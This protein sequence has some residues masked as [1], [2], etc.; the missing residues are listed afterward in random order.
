MKRRHGSTRPLLAVE[1]LEDR[2]CPSGQVLGAALTTPDAVTQAHV[3]AAYG[4]LP[5]AFEA[6]Q[7]Q[8]DSQVNFLS[9]GNGYTLFLK[10]SEAVLDLHAAASDQ[11]LTM[12]LVGANAR[13]QA[14]GL[15]QQAGASNYLIGN[16]PSQWH[17]HIANFD[18]VEY[19][20]VYAGINE[21]YY[22]NQRQ[23][24]YDF[25][26]APGANPS[27]IKL[28]FQG[29]NDVSLDSQGNLVLHTADGDVVEHA[30]VVYQQSNGVR[31]AVTGQ[32][33]LQENGQIGFEVGTY[34]P[35]QP[36]VID[37]V[38]ALSYST[39]LGGS[40]SEIGYSIAVDGAGN[41]YVTGHTNSTDFPTKNPLQPTNRGLVPGTSSNVFVTKLNPTGTALVYSTYLG[42]DGHDVGKSIALFTDPSGKTFACVT[43]STQSANFPTSPGAL[44]TVFGGGSV[45]TFVAELNDTGTALVYSTYLG[46]SGSDDG[47]GIAVDARGNAHVTGATTST[48]FP[49]TPGALQPTKGSTR[50]WV[51][52]LNPT[53]A[54]VY[55]TYFGGD[56]S[57]LSNAIAVDG[58][59]NT[60]LTGGSASL[61]FPTTVGAFQTTPGGQTDAFVAKLN[62][63]GTALV[64]STYLG[65]S[66]SDVGN[67][68]AVDS[69]GNAYVTGA[70]G[71]TN[72][73]VSAN[74]YLS[75]NS[76]YDAFV[77]KLN[78]TG[79]QLLYSSYLGGNSGTNNSSPV[80]GIAVDGAGNAYVTGYTFATNFPVTANASQP[81]KGGAVGNANAFVTKFNPAAPT[82][83][84]SLLYSSYLGG[85]GSSG[86]DTGY[87]IAVDGAGN[88]Y[89]TGEAGSN[90]FPTT[91]GSFQPTFG[92]PLHT[93]DAFVTK[94]PN[95]SAGMSTLAV[96]GFP[97]PASAG[98]IGNLTITAG[99]GFGGTN[100][101]YTG[102][103]HFTSSDSQA[104]LP[105]DYT[106][107]AAVQGVHTF[108][109]TLKTVGTQSLTASDMIGGITGSQTGIAVNPAAASTLSLA[110]FPSPTNVGVAGSFTVTARDA[111]G[112]RATGYTGTVHLNSSDL[113]AVLPGDYT[114]TAADNGEHAFSATLNTT[115]TQSLTV[116]DT[117]T[118]GIT[119]SQ[120]GITVNPAAAPASTLSVAGF[121]S[122]TTAGVAHA[123]TVTARD[124]SGNIATGYRGTV[125]FSSSDPQAVLPVNYTFTAA[126]QGVHTFSAALKT[127]GA[128]SLTATDTVTG[129]IA[130]SAAGIVVNPA[131]ASHFSIS[132]PTSVSAGAAF[133]LTVTARDPYGNVAIGYTGTV[134]FRSSNSNA[135]LPL[136]TT[137]TA[138]D[139]GVHTF[140]NRTTLRRR[141]TKTVSVTDTLDST[142]TGTVNINVV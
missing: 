136:D 92:G 35:T 36:L 50:A 88:A 131:A 76:S 101:A 77:A 122:P 42:G 16:D 6:N 18:R 46:G 64:Y 85:S 123:V 91:P 59:F 47:R 15:D 115:G 55:S 125:Q 116:T 78:P 100:T 54:L 44:Q 107:T 27:T 140:V 21:V 17:T 103:V 133:S 49:T 142:I 48:N 80:G 86:G 114:L 63:T 129:N 120:A 119:G 41:A 84:A 30:P 75:T 132:A 134:H 7:G 138:S 126:D 51:A 108:N 93:G 94:V 83:A 137:F 104:V 72:F 2:L 60:Y 130:G 61:T 23:L 139:G 109:I 8:T 82:G 10:P 124:A 3:S 53:G 66:S 39:F 96:A 20:N 52:E 5:L 71:S 89:V 117:A 141:G 38:L 102:T 33:V 105:A 1:C 43:G 32:Y 121:P 90:D 25:I 40:G 11:L 24:E 56:S 65:G 69:A 98:V 87:G 31:Q 135:T 45:D 29:A 128:Q 22:G 37:P 57:A 79:S 13:A 70:T 68:I 81:T 19:A 73:P 95:P 97:S 106:F 127:A 74:A 111:F 62:D 28:S 67:G 58:A 99:N 113:L 12:R 34:D 110:G 9:R 14:V 112:N 118:T 26:V 4:Q